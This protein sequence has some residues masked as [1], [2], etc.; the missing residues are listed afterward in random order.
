MYSRKNIKL[1]QTCYF[2]NSDRRCFGRQWPIL[3]FGTEEDIEFF[4]SIGSSVFLS[5]N[6]QTSHRCH[7]EL[8]GFPASYL[9][10]RVLPFPAI[11]AEMINFL[12]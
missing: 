12:D 10:S 9:L 5:Y 8:S 4:K 1:Q 7:Q 6:N 2:G 3:L 11:G